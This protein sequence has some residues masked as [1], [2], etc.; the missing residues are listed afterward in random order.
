MGFHCADP[1][2][3]CSYLRLL[4]SSTT[5]D[6]E[7]M[8]ATVDTKDCDQSV[9]EYKSKLGSVAMAYE[10]LIRRFTNAAES[11]SHEFPASAAKDAAKVEAQ[12]NV[13][14]SWASTFIPRHTG[15]SRARLSKQA[16]L[17]MMPYLVAMAYAVRVKLD[18]HYVEGG[19]AAESE[20]AE[21]MDRSRSLVDQFNA[22]LRTAMD[23]MLQKSSLLDVALDYNL[24]LMTYAL[25]METLRKSVLIMLAPQNPPGVIETWDDG[26]SDIR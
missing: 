17:E 15:D 21:Y 23:M 13:L 26:L 16:K 4:E 11:D 10:P 18:V 22:Q 6:I 24:A 20:K 2:K 5:E 9:R 19:V 3:T 14:Y 12:A 1:A 25:L 8:I 7:A